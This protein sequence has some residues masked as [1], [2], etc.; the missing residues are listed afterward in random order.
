MESIRI[1]VLLLI[2]SST[3]AN[4]QYF[5]NTTSDFNNDYDIGEYFLKSHLNLISY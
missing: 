5:E 1:F 4:C 3:V 2:A